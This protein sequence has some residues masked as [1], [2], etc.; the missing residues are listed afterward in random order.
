MNSLTEWTLS[1]LVTF[2]VPI[3]LLVSYVGSLG[4]PFPITL[5]IIAA[6][7]LAREGI[8]DWQ[9]AILACLAGAAL[10]DNS[11]YLLGHWAQQWLKG[12]FGEKLFWQRGLIIFNRQGGWAIL[13]TRFWLTPLAP[14]INLIAG[15]R[16][17][18]GRFLF[19]DLVGQLL[20]VLFFGGLGYIFDEQW[21]L[22]SQTVTNF[23]ELS[24]VLAALAAGVY[25]WV[26]WHKKNRSQTNHGLGA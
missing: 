21:R 22:V 6:G 13:L 12:R 2:G 5:V 18:Y 23:S 8:L 10:A 26:L 4:I 15:S 24:I 14:A 19:F 25:F 20:W 9:M 16:Y 7:A 17:P 3:L 1:N 11:E